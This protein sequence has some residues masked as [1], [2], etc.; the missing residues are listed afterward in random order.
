[1][2]YK[3]RKPCAHPGCPALTDQRYCP[4]H[5]RQQHRDYNQHQRRPDSNQVYGRRWRTIRNLY[6]AAHPLCE[7]CLA[8]G[9]C[10][11]AEEVHH[12]VPV[13]EGGSHADSNLQALCRSCHARI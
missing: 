1:M 3:A 5:T 13:A 7:Q 12:V 9:R 10:V 11:R 2:P 6:I 4:E 8:A